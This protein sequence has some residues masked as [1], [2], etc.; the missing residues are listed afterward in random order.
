MIRLT[1]QQTEQ[2]SQTDTI[3]LT[4]DILDEYN[5]FRNIDTGDIWIEDDLFDDYDT[6][7]IKNILK[8][9]IDVVNPDGTVFD[10]IDLEPIETNTI[11]DDIETINIK[12][13]IDI[14]TDDGIAID[15]SKKVKIL[16]EPNRLR[17]TSNEIKKNIFIKNQKEY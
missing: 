15:A 7:A 9:I 8:E 16:T 6:Q 3:N 17:I 2:K 13:D 5:L 11:P 14:L 1:T 4:D 10:D 12:N